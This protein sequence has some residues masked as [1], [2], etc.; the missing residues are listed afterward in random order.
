MLDGPYDS[1]VLLTDLPARS[2]FVTLC[3]HKM[4][5]ASGTGSAQMPPKRI[6]VSFLAVVLALLSFAVP[7]MRAQTVL[8]TRLSSD[9]LSLDPGTL[10]DDNTDAVEMHMI[11]GLVASR[12]DGSIGPM[13]ASSWTISPDG[14]TYTF[15]LRHDVHFHNGSLLM[16]K[17]V[18][19]SLHRYLKPETHWRCRADLS[20]SGMTEITSIEAPNPFTVVLHLSKAAPLFLK[21]I[22]RA[23]CGGTGILHPDSVDR[24]GK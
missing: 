5:S 23:E 6:V 10:R 16:S 11:E 7:A 22:A 20:P 18:V 13:L 8:R 24:D 3:A 21:T 15:L 19:W 1:N 17:E 4:Q 2:T 9:I 12:E 14:K